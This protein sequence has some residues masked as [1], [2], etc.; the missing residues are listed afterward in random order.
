MNPNSFPG[1]K[2]STKAASNTAPMIIS[3]PEIFVGM[4]TSCQ[5]NT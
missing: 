5:S 2:I 3:R 1:G 4:K